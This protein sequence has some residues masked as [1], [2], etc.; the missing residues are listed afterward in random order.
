MGD[1][2][3]E[4][5]LELNKLYNMDCMEGMRR[6]PDKYFE[7]AIVDP[8]YGIGIGTMNYTKSGAVRSRGNNLANR[9]DYRKKGD[10]DVRPSAEYF[11]ELMRVSANQI[12]WGGNYFSDHLPPSK[13]FIV[14]D[15]RTDEKYS[16]DFA[17][18][19]LAW[20]S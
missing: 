13:S 18:C 1:K 14:W 10:W 19:E 4:Q 7:L 17:D 15:K 3:S 8:P 16:N 11:A 5:I 6:F 9:R 20:C 2:N 12:I